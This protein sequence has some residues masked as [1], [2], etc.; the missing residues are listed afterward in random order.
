MFL[1]LENFNVEWLQCKNYNILTRLKICGAIKETTMVVLENNWV[2]NWLLK[3]LVLL[4]VAG[5]SITLF[6]IIKQLKVSFQSYLV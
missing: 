2:D 6:K 1:N 5:F 4:F 3:I